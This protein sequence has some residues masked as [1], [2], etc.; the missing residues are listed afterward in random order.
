MPN[1]QIVGEALA[2]AAQIE[3]DLASLEE[4]KNKANP[5]EQAISDTEA[6][7]AAKKRWIETH[8][9]TWLIAVLAANEDM[10]GRLLTQR[11][12][13]TK[14]KEDLTRANEA[15]QGAA[16]GFKKVDM[17]NRVAECYWAIAKNLDS[18]CEHQ[19]A[20]E[21]FENGFAGYKAAAQRLPRFSDFYLNYATYMK[22]WSEIEV[23]KQAH[24][25]QKYDTAMQHYEATANLLEPSKLWNYLAPNFLAWSILE[26]AED[27]SRND[28]SEESISA[29]KKAVAFFQ[30]SKQTLQTV[31]EKTEKE[32]EKTLTK[33]LAEAAEIREQFSRGRI[34]IEEAKILN[35]QGNHTASSQKYGS[36][37][38]I[39]QKLSQADE[40]QIGGEAK[41]L[42]YLCQ[43]WQKMTLAEAR[44]SPTMYAEAAGLFKLANEHTSTQAES[45]LALG[46]SSFCKALVGFPLGWRCVRLPV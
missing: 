43:A 27:L 7:V 17:P 22:A 18:M 37:A 33:R 39:F 1:S 5:L 20:S 31:M 46:H 29:F 14:N 12:H 13:L 30:Q 9:R 15:Y 25:S 38:E 3:A 4:E 44:S 45:L 23:A 40:E 8:P 34:V 32:D 11:Y 19:K 16:E 24:R 35:R 36:A 28:N 42:V 6:A 10:L 26:H 2:K 41:P 21:N